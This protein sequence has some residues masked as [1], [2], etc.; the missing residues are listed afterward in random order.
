[1]EHLDRI[2][3]LDCAGVQTKR[4]LHARIAD[5]LQFPDWYGNNLDALMDCLTD[6]YPKTQVIIQ[7][8][9]T[10]ED[11]ADIFWEVFREAEEANPC[12]QVYFA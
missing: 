7:N 6:L 5:A 1:M 4:E 12:L 2:F 11:W 10:L 9:Q 3:T 8:R